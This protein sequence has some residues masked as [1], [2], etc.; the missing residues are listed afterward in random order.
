[1]LEQTKKAFNLD[2]GDAYQYSVAKCHVITMD[3][4]F[5]KITAKGVCGKPARVKFGEFVKA[6]Y[7]T[8]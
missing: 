7:N 8:V 1:M 4:N 5:A 3:S 2:F 6:E